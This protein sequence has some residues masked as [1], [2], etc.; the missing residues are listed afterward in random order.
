ME[1]D[2]IDFLKT[3]LSLYISHFKVLAAMKTPDS[4]YVV[5]DVRNA[6]AQVKGDQIKGALPIAA[7][8]LSSRLSEL[9]ASKTYVVYDWTSGTTLGKEALLILLSNGFKAFELAGD[10]EGWKGMHL[11]LEPAQ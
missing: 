4:P 1:Q 8:D 11:P 10:L 3:Y 7:K 6:P 2:K 9:D 5:L